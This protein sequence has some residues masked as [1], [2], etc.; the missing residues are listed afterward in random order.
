MVQN[1]RI[2][3]VSAIMA[4]GFLSACAAP[5]E[6]TIT[7]AWQVDYAINEE[8]REC[9][10]DII[11][12]SVADEIETRIDADQVFEELWQACPELAL[13]ADP[14]GR[15][16][17][18]DSVREAGT[19]SVASADSDTPEGSEPEGRDTAESTGNESGS[20]SD[21]G[22]SGG[23]DGGSDAG[24]ESGSDS[25]SGGR[26]RGSN[27]NNGGGNGSEGS[28]PGKGSRANEDE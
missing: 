27:A 24:S 3:A 23:S 10:F 17:D 25:D 12:Q 28:S 20:G 14:D 9:R 15:G 5:N 11:S 1:S 19:F 8:E 2:F 26:G 18:Q 13:I 22:S 16:G 6:S 7:R 21:G 4:A